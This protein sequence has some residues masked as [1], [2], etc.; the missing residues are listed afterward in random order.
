MAKQTPMWDLTPPPPMDFEL[1]VIIWC[2]RDC[3]IKDDIT[4]QNDL[5][6]TCICNIEGLDRQ[7]TDTHYRSKK[8]IGNFNWRFKFPISLPVKPWPRLKF[9]I[10]DRD[11]IAANDAIGQTQMPLKSLCKKA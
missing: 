8:G 2:V 9:Q 3:A 4:E 7:K 10:W 11:L 6:C 1:R 5:Y